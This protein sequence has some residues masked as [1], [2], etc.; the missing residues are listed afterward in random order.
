MYIIVLMVIVFLSV[1]L[2]MSLRAIYLLLSKSVLTKHHVL[3]MSVMPT[4][5]IKQQLQLLLPN[6][7]RIVNMSLSSG[8]F[9]QELLGAVIT[10]VLKKPSLNKNELKN[11]RP[12]ANLHFVSTVIEKCAVTQ[13]NRLIDTHK[14][15]EPMESAYKTCHSTETALACVHND[16]CRALDD[17]KAVLLVM[18]DLSAAFDTVD[19][20][21]LLQRVGKTNSVLLIQPNFGFFRIWNLDLVGYLLLVHFHKTLCLNMDFHKDLLLVPLDLVYIPMSSVVYCVFTT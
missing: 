14:L 20:K 10:P 6:L 12:V 2:N 3:L 1:N 4:W 17:Q 11:Y 7:T 16:F 8:I 5:I 15:S 18:L 9:P 21:I 13:Y 19:R